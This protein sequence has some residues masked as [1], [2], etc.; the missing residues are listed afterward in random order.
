MDESLLTS[1]KAQIKRSEGLRLKPYKDSRGILTIGYGHNLEQAITQRVADLIFEEDFAAA[2]LFAQNIPEYHQLCSARQ[3]VLVDMVFNMG[4]AKVMK[5]E[6]MRAAVRRGDFAE[7]KRQMLDSAWHR[8]V[9]R[10]AEHLAEI[11]E[12]GVFT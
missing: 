1:L 3:A 12:S 4:Y 7:A 8:Q 9:G 6:K 5:F 10:R 11:M 2:A